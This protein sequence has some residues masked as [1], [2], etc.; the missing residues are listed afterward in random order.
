[1]LPLTSRTRRVSTWVISW[2][3][4]AATSAP[5]L[6]RGC[7]WAPRRVRRSVIGPARGASSALSSGDDR[8]RLPCRP[9]RAGRS[10]SCAVQVRNAGLESVE[11]LRP[12]WLQSRVSG[13]CRVAV[14]SGPTVRAGVDQRRSLIAC[15]SRT[16]RPSDQHQRLPSAQASSGRRL[17]TDQSSAAS[18]CAPRRDPPA[19]AAR[20]AGRVGRPG[21]ATAGRS[22]PVPPCS[23]RRGRSRRSRGA[24][25]PARSWSA[26]AARAR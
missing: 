13:S 22:R 11:L 15:S 2:S 9:G 23:R 5:Q 17:R 3:R 24:R 26:A 10:A 6:G 14:D 8:Q 16:G 20:A 7:R 4:L 21:A 12:A 18:G 25:G 1:M 19:A